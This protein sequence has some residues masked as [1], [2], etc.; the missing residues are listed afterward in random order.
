MHHGSPGDLDF[1][2]ARGGGA[3]S[4][5]LS[6][7]GNLAESRFHTPQLRPKLG[8]LLVDRSR[9][10]TSDDGFGPRLAR[11]RRSDAEE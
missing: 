7:V 2:D 8:E 1:A 5:R 10:A 3:L 4:E 11:R 6:A 9:L